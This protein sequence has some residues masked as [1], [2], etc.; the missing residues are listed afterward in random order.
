[1]NITVNEMLSNK[2]NML[3]SKMSKAPAIVSDQPM[4]KPIGTENVAFGRSANIAKVAKKAAVPAALALAALFASCQY[5]EQYVDIDDSKLMEKMDKIIELLQAAK[6]AGESTNA[7]V[8]AW[9]AEYQ[10]GKMSYEQFTTNVEALLRNI[11]KNVSHI[12]STLTAHADNFNSF[13]NEYQQNSANFDLKLDSLLN[14][15]KT[16]IQAL[17]N[18]NKDFDNMN[19]NFNNMK[20]STDSLYNLLENHFELVDSVTAQNLQ[21]MLNAQD[22]TQQALLA[23]INDF[24]QTYVTTEAQ[25]AADYKEQLDSLNAKFD[26]MIGKFANFE[27][28]FAN[29]SNNMADKADTVIAKMDAYK[30]SYKAYQ[31]SMMALINNFKADNAAYQDSM[32]TL[33]NNFKIENAANQDSLKA[34]AAEANSYLA[35]MRDSVAPMIEAIRNIR[36]EGNSDITFNEFKAYMQQRDS[37]NQ[38]NYFNNLQQMFEALGLDSISAYVKDIDEVENIINGKIDSLQTSFNTLLN[39]DLSNPDQAVLNKLS[40]IYQFIQTHDFCHCNCNNTQNHEG[41][42]QG[43][44]L[45]DFGGLFSQVREILNAKSKTYVPEIHE[46]YA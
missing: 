9:Y 46:F 16:K 32:M 43:G 30:N 20:L 33:V 36:N 35:E 25:N 2:A 7:T 41:T 40:E 26:R 24:K 4:P 22:T 6:A 31:D 3:N 10:A 13:Y 12:D 21:I 29:Y 19:L 8:L 44:N 34:A 5:T 1:M 45:N 38:T 37:V 28:D 18:I 11:D 39:M 42:D 14:N 23:A 27:V 15:D 17:T